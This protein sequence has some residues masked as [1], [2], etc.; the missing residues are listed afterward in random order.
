MTFIYI[1]RKSSFPASQT[2]HCAV[3]YDN[4]VKRVNTISGKTQS[5]KVTVNVHIESLHVVKRMNFYYV[6][7]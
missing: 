4:R 2:T 5:V 3:D 1:K 7:I 6:M